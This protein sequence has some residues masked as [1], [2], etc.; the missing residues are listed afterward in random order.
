MRRLPRGSQRVWWAPLGGQGILAPSSHAHPRHCLS[1]TCPAGC[2]PDPTALGPVP[3]K[4]RLRDCTCLGRNPGGEPHTV[5]PSGGNSQLDIW[6]SHGVG[7]PTFTLLSPN[8]GATPR[9]ASCPAGGPR[10][11]TLLALA[12]AVPTTQ[13]ALSSLSLTTLS[14]YLQLFPSFRAQGKCRKS[15]VLGCTD[16]S[17]CLEASAWGHRAP[18]LKFE[19]NPAR[20]PHLGASSAPACS[21]APPTPSLRSPGIRA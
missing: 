13:E 15:I 8:L 20:H 10:L 6:G 17:S 5:R 2:L 7:A 18:C 9:L 16:P 14:L 11:P 4:H 1:F 3:P 21:I 19:W 12:E